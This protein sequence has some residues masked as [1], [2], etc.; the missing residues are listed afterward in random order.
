MGSPRCTPWRPARSARP[1]TCDVFL[2][3]I[4]QRTGIAFAIVDE[5]EES[6]L[7]FLAVKQALRRR[8]PLRGAW[9]LL[10]EVGGGSTEPHAPAPGPTQPIGRVRARRDPAAAAARPAPADARRA[11]VAAQAVDCQRHRRDQG[12]Q[13]AAARDPHGG[14]GRRRALCRLANPRGGRRRRRARGWPRGVSGVLRSSRAARRGAAGRALSIAGRRGRDARAVAARLPRAAVR[15]TGA[16]AWSSRTRR[17]GPACCWT[18]PIPADGRAPRNSNSRC[19][20][21]RRRSGTRTASIARTAGTSRRW[22]CSCS[23]RSGT[24]TAWAAASGCCCRSPRCSTT[25]AST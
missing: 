17:C 8:A 6:R 14:D 3:R 20:P 21:A 16:Q 10:T 2:D 7:V 19:S 1:A 12:R 5:A 24:T 25:S 4:Q 13:S 22:R 18:R 15:D 9:T 11:A 23:T